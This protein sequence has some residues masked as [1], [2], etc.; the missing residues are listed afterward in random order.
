[1]D[2]LYIEGKQI[3]ISVHA[4]KKARERDVAFPN[5]VHSALKTGKMQKFGKHGIKFV[6]K[7]K[8]GGSIVCVGEDLGQTII[9]KTIERGN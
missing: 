8:A 6:S 5:Q 7:S 3:I 4:V 2:D 1:M 9:I